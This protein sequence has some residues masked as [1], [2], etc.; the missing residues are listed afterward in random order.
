MLMLLTEAAAE[1]GVRTGN[2]QN[3]MRACV[4]ATW[5][6]CSVR[7]S[8]DQ[9]PCIIEAAAVEV[10][11]RCTAHKEIVFLWGRGGREER[12]KGNVVNH[13]RWHLNDNTKKQDQHQHV[14]NMT[15]II[16]KTKHHAHHLSYVVM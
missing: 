14:I 13:H 3:R 5:V 10:G 9:V 1:D 8:V 4:Q 15:T 16:K 12:L 7:Y 11:S 2:L 6:S